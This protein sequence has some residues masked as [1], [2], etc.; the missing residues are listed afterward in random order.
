[1]KLFQLVSRRVGHPA[2]GRAGQRSIHEARAGG[3]AE[4]GQR[5]GFCRGDP[6]AL[7][8]ERTRFRRIGLLRVQRRQSFVGDFHDHPADA[9]GKHIVRDAIVAGGKRGAQ[10][11][12]IGEVGAV[13]VV[14]LD[15]ETALR[16]ADRLFDI[17][18][19]LIEGPAGHLGPA[20]VDGAPQ[21][22]RFGV[23]GCI[24]VDLLEEYFSLLIAGQRL[25]GASCFRV[26]LPGFVG[27]ERK[28]LNDERARRFRLVIGCRAR[29]DRCRF[30]ARAAS[31]TQMRPH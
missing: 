19:L 30:S 28:L 21:P 17:R 8:F 15:H 11:E 25:V 23:G 29:S 22:E 10:V 20:L 13:V 6:V 24:D 4:R 12:Q 31:R 7:L 2:G 27:C 16:G 26:R 3:I 14:V 5:L 9:V 18:F 1:M